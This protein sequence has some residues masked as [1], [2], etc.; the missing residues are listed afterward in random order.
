MEKTLFDFLK[1]NDVEYKENLEMKNLSSVRIGGKAEVVVF[2]DTDEKMVSVLDFLEE[3]KIDYKIIGRITNVL[4]PDG[5]INKV[6]IKT[7]KLCGMEVIGDR[8]RLCAGELIAPLA[9]K[10][11]K[12]GID[13]FSRLS[14]IPGSVGGMITNNAGAFGMEIGDV[15]CSSVA[16]SPKKKELY[17]LDKSDLKLGYRSS[18]FKSSDMVILSAEFTFINEA[19]D[20]ILKRIREIRNLRRSSQ[21]IDKPSL[22][23]VF[24][25]PCGD[26]AARLIDNAGLKG[27]CVGDAQISVRHAGF[28]VN[29][30]NA[31]ASDY[32]RLVEH[33]KQVVY[34]KYNVLLEE[35][36]EIL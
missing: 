3:N 24:K 33:I 20:V 34:E 9:N 14:G 32:C 5:I 8:I 26:F 10:L 11:A 35:E 22:G 28:I 6:L 29:K 13:G 30:G 12:A 4:M 18:V 19:P 31:T 2:P 17:Y 7:D 21:P 36:I 1:L 27:Y 23:S 16:Y 25:R 15:I